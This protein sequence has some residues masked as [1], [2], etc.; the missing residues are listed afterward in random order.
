M[1]YFEDQEFKKLNMDSEWDYELIGEDWIDGQPQKRPMTYR[2]FL[3][4]LGTDAMREGLHENVW[5]NALMSDYHPPK[6]DQY[7]PSKWIITDMRFPNEM[8]AVKDKQGITIHVSKGYVLT[9]DLENLNNIHASETA[10]DG[11]IFDYYIV[12]DGT[13][14]E[15]IKKVRQILKE[16]GIL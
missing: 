12:N 15:L 2:D 16:E 4:K 3:Q 8:D 7:Y 13:I 1:E 10:L 14:E 5:V 9:G 11:Y 6:M